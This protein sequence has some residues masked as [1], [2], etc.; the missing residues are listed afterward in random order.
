MTNLKKL[1]LWNVQD[2]KLIEKQ[3]QKLSKLEL[4]MFAV[5]FYFPYQYLLEAACKS[6][7]FRT[8]Y[9]YD[10]AFENNFQQMIKD[11]IDGRGQCCIVS[12]E[13]L[14][15]YLH[16]GTFYRIKGLL[17]ED[18]LHSIEKYRNI[19]ILPVNDEVFIFLT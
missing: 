2:T 16:R 6:Q 19:K 10:F 8:I 3:F 1:R 13:P 12:G 11:L 7:K 15:I 9:V 5:C 4:M 14:F 18:N 17:T